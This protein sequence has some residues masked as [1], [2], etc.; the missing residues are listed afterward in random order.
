VLGNRSRSYY[1]TE[2]AAG[3]NH[4]EAMRG[5]KRRC[6]QR[7]AADD[8]RRTENDDP[9]W[10]LGATLTSSAAGSTPAASSSDNSFSDPERC[11]DR[12]TNAEEPGMSRGSVWCAR[13]RRGQGLSGVQL[14]GGL[15]FFAA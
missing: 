11:F 15:R 2:I 12:L 4:N 9:G 14:R 1:G 10:T 13:R 3:M 7:L 8:L 5:L 6:R